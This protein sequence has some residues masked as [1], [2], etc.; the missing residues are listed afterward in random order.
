ML[1]VDADAARRHLHTIENGVISERAHGAGIGLQLSGDQVF[2]M[3]RRKRMMRGGPALTFVVILE[4][5]KIRDPY[6]AII[7]R[8]VADT[9]EGLVLLCEL[10]RQRETKRTRGREDRVVMLLDLRF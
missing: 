5:G 7:V 10:L 3:W 4:H 1:L 8:G 9:L 6:P 2:F